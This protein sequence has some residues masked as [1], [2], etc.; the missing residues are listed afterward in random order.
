MLLTLK[1][2]DQLIDLNGALHTKIFNKSKQEWQ[3]CHVDFSKSEI[4]KCFD[5]DVPVIPKDEL[6]SYKKIIARA[7]DLIDIEQIER[8]ILTNIN[9]FKYE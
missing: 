9:R 8:S 1:Y 5:L 3:A 4:K 2:N 7:V 6:L